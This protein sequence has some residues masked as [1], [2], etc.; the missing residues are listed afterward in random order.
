MAY[1]IEAG[2]LWAAGAG[3][4]FP[5]RGPV[6]LVEDVV[7]STIREIVVDLSPIRRSG[8]RVHR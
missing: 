2:R 4:A 1:G 5:S 6:R 7:A 3:E 8:R